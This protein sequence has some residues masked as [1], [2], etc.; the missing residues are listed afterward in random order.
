MALLDHPDSFAVIVP[1]LDDPVGER[2]IDTE[3]LFPER[4]M[5]S[6][7]GTWEGGNRYPLNS[8]R[9]FAGTGLVADTGHESTTTSHMSRELI[10]IL[11]GY[12][13]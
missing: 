2:R 13:F 8:M 5:E 9:R 10:K 4:C 11:P 1:G 6:H 7:F 3:R 12:N